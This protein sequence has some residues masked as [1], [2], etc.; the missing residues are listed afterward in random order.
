MLTLPRAVPSMGTRRVLFLP[1]VGDILAITTTEAAAADNISCYLTRSAGG[2]RPATR[3]SPRTAG[4]AP[5][6]TTSCP[7]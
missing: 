7:A 3:P 2:L 1:T 5:R 6:R 4:T